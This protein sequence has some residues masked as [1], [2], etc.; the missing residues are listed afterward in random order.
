MLIAT[1][2]ALGRRTPGGRRAVVA[3]AVA[4][5]A[6]AAT[7]GIVRLAVGPSFYIKANG[8]NAGWEIFDYNVANGIT[9]D[10]L[11]QTMS[12]VPLLAVVAFRRWPLELKAFGIAVVPAWFLIHV[13]TAV[14]AES[15]LVLVP[16]A[17][18][19]VPGAL[20][21]LRAAASPATDSAPR[22]AAAPSA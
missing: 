16:Y 1:G 9:W 22:S 14:L 19:F 10:H 11:F 4:L 21:G 12:I 8:R 5:G 3:G 13:F 7:Y 2:V 6:F 18:V 20:A 15:R 17:L